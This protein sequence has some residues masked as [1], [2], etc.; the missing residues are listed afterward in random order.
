VRAAVAVLI[1]LF[2]ELFGI[3][4]NEPGA[5]S[6]RTLTLLGLLLNVA[7]EVAGR[8]GWRL[9]LQA[10]VRMLVDI[11]LLTAGLYDAG[12]IAAAQALSVYVIVPVYAAL[13]LSSTAALVGTAY[14][15]AA[16]LA[17]VGAQTAGWLSTPRAPL[18]NAA[19]IVAFNLLVLNVVGVMVAWL[20]ERYRRSRR[21]VRALNAE[22]ER[23]HDASLRFSAELQRS[24]RLYALGEV[25]AGVT[26]EMR[27]VLTAAVS[28]NHLLRRSL[29][30][31]DA[32]AKRHADQIEHSLTSASRILS[33]VLDT[34][35]QP[36]SERVRVSLADV[37]ARVVALKGYDI[38]RDGIALH[39]EMPATLP[40]VSAVPFQLDQVLLNL[41]NNAHDAVRGRQPQ[42]TIWI[43]G[44]TG[45]GVAV[46]EVRDSGPGIPAEALP[47][48][49]EPFFTTKA[50]GTGLGLAISAGIVREA[51]GEL[52]AANHPEGGAAFRVALPAATS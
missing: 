34:A 42:G 43:A 25:V 20:A 6:I 17:M 50:S 4:P 40:L 46:V 23:T 15:T 22:L 11:T 47:R 19:G 24:A 38:R 3:G 35:R 29:S 9:R 31:A 14:A 26:H 36:S 5:S 13:M 32:D 37:V 51:G 10:F 27:N 21:E 49:F 48:L 12:G 41:V 45:L 28:H 52:T 33:N 7:Y 1:L 30:E 18:P 44:R 8:T 2:N 39:V 16:F